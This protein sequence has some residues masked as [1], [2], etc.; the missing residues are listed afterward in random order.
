MT[1]QAAYSFLG[2]HASIN[3]IDIE[4]FFTGDDAII[5]EPL[6][7]KS[8]LIVGAGGGATVNVKGT[9]AYKFTC[10]LLAS[11]PT[12]DVFTIFYEALRVGVITPALFHVEDSNGLAQFTGNCVLEG[13]PADFHLGEKDSGRT[14]VWL[15]P[16]AIAVPA[17]TGTVF[18]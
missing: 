17:H 16:N 1:V 5:C 11:S 18:A 4:G 9:N 3:G 12:N 7:T 14:W 8:E 15:C 13:P 6:E 2:V 10:K